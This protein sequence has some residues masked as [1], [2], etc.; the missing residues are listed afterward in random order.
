VSWLVEQ[1]AAS[2]TPLKRTAARQSVQSGRDQLQQP[3]SERRPSGWWEKTFPTLA[4]HAWYSSLFF[5][6][7]VM[8]VLL[9]RNKGSKEAGVMQSALS[10]QAMH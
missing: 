2:G 3:Q 5:D 7:H 4:E 8:V 9:R 10:E 6:V 1:V